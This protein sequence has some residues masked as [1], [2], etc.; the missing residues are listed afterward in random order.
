MFDILLV[1]QGAEA[2]AV[3]RGLSRAHANLPILPL[4]MGAVTTTQRLTAALNQGNLVAGSRALVLGVAGS[5]SPQLEIGDVVVYQVLIDGAPLPGMPIGKHYPGEQSPADSSTDP[6]TR[7]SPLPPLCQWQCHWEPRILQRLPQVQVVTA[8]SCDRLL[9]QAN[10]K[11]WL[12]ASTGAVAVDMEAA[13]IAQVLLPEGIEI[14]TVRV[15]SD[16]SAE[17]LPNLAPAMEAE[18]TLDTWKLAIALVRQPQAA[19]RLIRGSLQALQ[20]LEEV[21]YQLLR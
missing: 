9:Y 1:P 3:R 17:D 7:R 18:G 13:A 2:A 15:I 19:F 10:E 4:A 11:S 21:T 8:V 16:D 6:S 14:S 20:Q 12:H 5:L